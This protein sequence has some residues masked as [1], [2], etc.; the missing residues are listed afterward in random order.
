M[1]FKNALL[2]I[3]PYYHLVARYLE[4]GA[5]DAF[6]AAGFN[7]D[8]IFVPGALEL[9]PAIAAKKEKYGCFVALGCIQRGDTSHYDVVVR[10]SAAGI[11]LLTVNHG[12]AVG[13][14]ILTVENEWQA[15]QRANPRYGDKGGEAARA[16]LSLWSLI[17][18]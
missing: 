8:R 17:N 11:T 5:T 1:A 16:A 4:Q 14:G 13:N 7:V 6:K 15:L 3:S 9:A 2:V 10:E 12:I 18:E